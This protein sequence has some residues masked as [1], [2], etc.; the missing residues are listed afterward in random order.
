M[1]LRV[2]KFE[3]CVMC[4]VHVWPYS[5][6][7]PTFLPTRHLF[8][9]VCLTCP[10]YQYL[11]GFS[12]HCLMFLVMNW[13]SKVTVLNN[14]QKEVF[15]TRAHWAVVCMNLA[16]VLFQSI[17]QGQDPS[18][19]TAIIKFLFSFAFTVLGRWHWLEQWLTYKYLKLSCIWF[20]CTAHIGPCFS[21]MVSF[22]IFI[23]LLERECYDKK[24]HT[25]LYNVLTS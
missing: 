6:F 8:L 11:C 19:H 15:Q 9:C 16:A 24:K 13:L 5:F 20:R 18:H 22:Y 4:V 10:T 1:L 14:H 12:V 3:F 7:C 2:V 25:G 21:H 23:R 17:F